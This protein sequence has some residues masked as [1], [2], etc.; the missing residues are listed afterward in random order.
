LVLKT[1]RAYLIFSLNQR[2]NANMGLQKDL[3]T[4]LT[5][6]NAGK[7]EFKLNEF[8]SFGFDFTFYTD[9]GLRYSKQVYD[10][11]AWC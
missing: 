4:Q 8:S 9:A 6:L 5:E 11:W 3:F 7:E 1:A 10:K 2:L